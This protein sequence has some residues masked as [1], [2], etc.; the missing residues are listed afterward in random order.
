MGAVFADGRNTLANAA[1][2]GGCE[3]R[4]MEELE[5]SYNSD[6]LRTFQGRLFFAD[7]DRSE[8]GVSD[9]SGG[10]AVCGG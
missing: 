2:L 8:P 3:A 1:L 7:R 6:D 10:S 9:I 5:H 4:S